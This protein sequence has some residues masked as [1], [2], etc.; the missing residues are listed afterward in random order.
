MLR[1]LQATG[2]A[3][4]D[5][6]IWQQHRPLDSAD[7]GRGSSMHWGQSRPSEV[8]SFR[9]VSGQSISFQGVTQQF[10]V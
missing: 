5:P 7:G 4:A 10:S 8:A 9:L 6:Q 1:L 2:S 3:M